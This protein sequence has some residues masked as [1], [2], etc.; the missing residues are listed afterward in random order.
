[1]AEISIADVNAAIVSLID[2]PEVDYKVGD[3][4]FKSGQKITQLLAIRRELMAN[5]AADIKLIAFDV[6]NIDELGIDDSREVL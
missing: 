1:M 6:L 2:T 4:A 3:K 5:P